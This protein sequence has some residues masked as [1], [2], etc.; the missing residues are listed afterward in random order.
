[1][2]ANI[3][4]KN[5]I[6]KYINKNLL[7]VEIIFFLKFFFSNFFFEK[8][9]VFVGVVYNHLSLPPHALRLG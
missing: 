1:M 9:L 6:A 3:V 7:L 2:G 5:N 4:K 8:F